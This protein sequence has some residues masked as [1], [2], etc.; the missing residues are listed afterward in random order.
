MIFAIAAG[1]GAVARYLVRAWF[2]SPAGTLAV[3]VV[4]AALLGWLV[5]GPA[6]RDQIWV[7]GTGFLGSFTTFST[8][9]WES[10]ENPS[11]IVVT[12]LAGLLGAWIGLSVG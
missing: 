6:D 11:S 9:M 5:A 7:M 2:N 4:G 8:W 3:N 10:K 1:L 12:L